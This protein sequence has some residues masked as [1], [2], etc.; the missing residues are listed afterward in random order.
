MPE[1]TRITRRTE[2]PSVTLSTKRPT[3][4]GLGSVTVL[5]SWISAT[6]GLTRG[7]AFSNWNRSFYL[8]VTSTSDS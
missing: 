4:K 2:G 3:W 8:A 5:G 6:N 7:T 1:D